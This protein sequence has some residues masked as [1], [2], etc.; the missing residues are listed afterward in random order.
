MGTD[1]NRNVFNLAECEVSASDHVQRCSFYF[2]KA[3]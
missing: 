1:T 2:H 3:R